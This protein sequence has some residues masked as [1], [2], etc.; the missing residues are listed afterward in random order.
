M[1][2]QR[3]LITSSVA[4]MAVVAAAVG[5][6]TMTRAET[7]AVAAPTTTAAASSDCG[8]DVCNF[9]AG[10]DS[11]GADDPA[12]SG[13][14]RSCNRV[15]FPDD[16]LTK[17]VSVKVD[18]TSGDGGWSNAHQCYAG[19]FYFSRAEDGYGAFLRDGT[20]YQLDVW[21]GDPKYTAHLNEDGSFDGVMLA[22][23]DGTSDFWWAPSPLGAVSPRWLADRAVA[24]MSLRAP[25]IGMTGG[26]PPDGMQWVGL[27]AWMW[28]ADPGESTTGPVTR[29]AAD[30]GISVTA[31]GTLDRTVWSMGD[32][33]VV[34]CSGPNAAG[35]PWVYGYG[36][37]PSPKCGYTYT[38]TSAG[39]P[40]EAFTV[41]VTAYWTVSWSGGGQSGTIPL[42]MSRSIPKRVGEVQAIIVPNP[43]QS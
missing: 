10:A 19:T 43:G 36:G 6:A 31:T 8:L 5:A 1:L 38:R 33:V 12:P 42:Q 26:D 20:T 39:M 30:G 40:N 28:V 11:G 17:P 15:T 21:G 13:G 37:Q 18:C 23:T 27:P 41:K 3:I 34:T 35:E 16:D 22:C 4:A 32:G 14:V 25:Q 2:R 29:S 7:V 24:A 9:S